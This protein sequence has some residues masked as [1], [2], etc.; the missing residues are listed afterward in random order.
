MPP[1]EPISPPQR[2]RISELLAQPALLVWSLYLIFT[3]FYVIDSGLPQPGDALVFPLLP[4]AL[5]RWDGKLDKTTSRM[6]RALLWFTLWVFVVN[7][8]WAFVQWKW[9]TPKDFLIHPFFYAYNAAVL[10][11]A[12]LIA[13]REPR[14]FLR[15][16]FDVMFWMIVFQVL[17]SFFLQMDKF[18]GAL[19][20]NSPNQL[21]YYALL[22]ACLFAMCQQPLGL[23][24]LRA[25]IGVTGCAYLAILSS[26]RASLAGIV[27][28]LLF[29]VFANPR[30]VILGAIVAVGLTMVGGPLAD[31]L[32]FSQY[33]ALENRDPNVSFAEERGYDRIW[34]SPEYLLTGAGEGD[35]ARFAKPNQPAREI[36][37]SL[38]T[39]V[40]G[41]GIVGVTLFMIFAVR[42]VRGGALR[43]ALV[44]IPAATYTVAHQGLR[45][46]MF[47]VVIAVYV[48]LKQVH[49]RPPP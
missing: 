36:H 7:F 22:S 28:L 24:R 42:M 11:S 9:T 45:F 31:A 34:D 2:Y 21:G 15:L 14:R 6:L 39:V 29:L 18:R 40:F 43:T 1:A 44:L 46:T 12:L 23:S 27:V 30:A 25:S 49:A 48:V 13:R 35:Y 5:S 20:F 19:F 3:P 33:R 8:A 17:S 10:F 41:Y 37:S 26:S 38:G 47:W 16:T 4:L 32:E